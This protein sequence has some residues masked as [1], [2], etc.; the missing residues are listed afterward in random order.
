MTTTE[1][2]IIAQSLDEIIAYT[3]RALF[4]RFAHNR[5]VII[6][7]VGERGSGKSLGGANIAIRDYAI[8]GD[9]IYTNMAIKQAI[10]VDDDTARSFGLDEG[11]IS[12]YEAKHISKQKFLALDS[13]YEGS[14]LFFDEFNLE[15]GEARRSSANVNLMTD[16]AI[17][18]LRKLKCALIYTVL[19]E[20]YVDTR[21][22]DNTDLFIRCSD[23]AFKAANL[24][25]RMPQ[26]I[27]FE[28]LL[29]PMSSRL[30]GYG[31]TYQEKGRPIGPIS[32]NLK[33]SWGLINTYQR[34]AVDQKKYTSMSS[35]D[36]QEE[37]G[38]ELMDVQ[39]VDEPRD[40]AVKR[41]PILVQLEQ[42]MAEFWE[43][44]ATDGEY[45]EI[46]SRELCHELNCDP[47]DW[48]QIVKQYIL[49]HFFRDDESFQVKY[50]KAGA[51][52]IIK[53]RL[54]V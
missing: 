26:G 27:A 32:L 39:V 46:T 25:G 53:N 12:T 19:N 54:F 41:D 13:R 14:C 43:N 31:N 6:G 29:Y 48:P 47:D 51:K 49:K 37:E 33:H 16:R 2:K 38:E 11:G 35:D 3:V 5:D 30:F 18:Q 21:I 45:I 9:P 50:G 15:Y 24:R 4:R 20:M 22:R 7:L 40:V 42:K 28:W 17:Q 36:E 52:Y 34:Q 1:T 44:H 23:T 8:H 10:S